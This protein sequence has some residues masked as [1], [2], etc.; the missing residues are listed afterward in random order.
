MYS[1]GFTPYFSNTSTFGTVKIEVHYF[2]IFQNRFLLT[3]FLKAF[4][5]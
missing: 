5:L 2:F 3:A 1:F 4:T